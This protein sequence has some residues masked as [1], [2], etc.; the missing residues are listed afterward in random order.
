MYFA[1]VRGG[2]GHNTAVLRTTTLKGMHNT[3][4]PC[5]GVGCTH[6][7]AEGGH[8]LSD[9]PEPPPPPENHPGGFLYLEFLGSS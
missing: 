1:C 4:I 3:S 8:A 5:V 2:E 6:D 9:A 7:V